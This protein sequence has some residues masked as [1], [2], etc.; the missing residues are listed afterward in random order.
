MTSIYRNSNSPYAN[1]T[2]NNSQTQPPPTPAVSAFTDCTS[3]EFNHSTDWKRSRTGT[4]ISSICPGDAV[5]NINLPVVP[6][7][8][9]PELEPKQQGVTA[10]ATP[11]PTPTAREHDGL[12]PLSTYY[13]PHEYVDVNG[14]KNKGFA[15]VPPP[16]GGEHGGGKPVDAHGQRRVC[17]LPVRRARLVFL[18][19]LA[20]VI[21]L[22]L[23]AGLGVGL[24]GR[25]KDG[26]GLGVGCAALPGGNST[27]GS[28]GNG[29]GSG[30][31]NDNNSKKPT[32]TTPSSS[33]SA[34]SP[35]TTD[36]LVPGVAHLTC[37]SSNGTIIGSPLFPS[38]NPTPSPSSSSSSSSSSTA[39]QYIILCDTNL[40]PTPSKQ[41]LASFRTQTLEE[42][43]AVCDSMNYYMKREDVAGVWNYIY[44]KGPG[45]GGCW[46]VGRKEGSEKGGN[47]GK[48]VMQENKGVSVVVVGVDEGGRV[49]D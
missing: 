19:V 36:G 42:C 15:P 44:E 48:R 49:L 31:G 20:V 23:G 33:S 41:D 29:N 6:E 4:V 45:R 22:G 12:Q 38:P 24:R 7:A 3:S 40:A 32:P 13:V 43:F 39:K 1:S 17:G 47:D 9:S 27:S 46:C 28:G 35:S 25:D 11:T 26:G 21:A 14:V 34:P 16:G 18:V 30:S 2:N 5:S 8:R 10:I 37:P